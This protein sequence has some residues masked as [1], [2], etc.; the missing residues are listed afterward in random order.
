MPSTAPPLIANEGRA[1][2]CQGD[3][4]RQPNSGLRH[5]KPF[6]K[7]AWCMAN[8]LQALPEASQSSV[9][10]QALG[11][12]G[13]F[14]PPRS[15]RSRCCP[16]YPF[17]CWPRG[18][19]PGSVWPCLQR[20]ELLFLGLQ[21]GLCPW[22]TCSLVGQRFLEDPSWQGWLLYRKESL[23]SSRRGE[24]AGRQIAREVRM[25]RG[26]FRKP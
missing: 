16:S 3:P 9:A 21:Q 13:L 12:A 19:Q 7:L 26:Q 10:Y 22:R 5:D 14:P 8:L 1:A 23:A 4:S 25:N 15:P 24:G 6:I 11:A 2:F 20:G 18:G 17:L